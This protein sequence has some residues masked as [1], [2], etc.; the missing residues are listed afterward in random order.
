MAKTLKTVSNMPARKPHPPNGAGRFIVR[1]WFPIGLVLLNALLSTVAEVL[2]KIG[3]THPSGI[4]LPAPTGFL[5][6]IFSFWVG[7]GIIAYIGSLSMW[8]GALPRLPLHLAYGFSSMVH[9]LVPLA[10]WLVLHETIPLGRMLG[11]LFILSGTLFLGLS[12]K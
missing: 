5:S 10:C 6:T 4:S 1:Q 7:A 9:L 3:A 2:L 12:H 8:L 11:M